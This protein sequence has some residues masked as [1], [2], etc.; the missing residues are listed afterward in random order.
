MQETSVGW[1]K[2]LAILDEGAVKRY[3]K[4][5]NIEDVDAPHSKI[6]LAVVDWFSHLNMFSDA[7]IVEIVK[8]LDV[9]FEGLAYDVQQEETPVFTIGV[10]DGRWV[11]CST[12]DDF[13]DAEVYESVEEMP[14]YGVTHIICD[15]VQLYFRLEHRAATIQQG[16]QNA[17]T[18]TE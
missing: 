17:A 8:E 9:C 6:Q 13:F 18:Q 11:S 2:A 14:E 10:C 3:C 15:V 4:Q 5:L 1:T 12:K 16:G 7:T